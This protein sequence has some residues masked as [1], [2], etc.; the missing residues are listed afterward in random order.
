MSG[1]YAPSAAELDAF[2]FRLVDGG[3]A[4]PE[5]PAIGAYR[6]CRLS[7]IGRAGVPPA[8]EKVFRRFVAE[9]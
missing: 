7:G 6:R 5:A 3:V 1:A 2:P 8:P 4:T 9:P